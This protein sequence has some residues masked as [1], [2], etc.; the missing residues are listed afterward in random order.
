MAQNSSLDCNW[1]LETDKLYGVDKDYLWNGAP[2]ASA[3][4]IVGAYAKR[5]AAPLDCGAYDAIEYSTVIDGVIEFHMV[6]ASTID[7]TADF[8]SFGNADVISVNSASV[9]NTLTLTPGIW[10]RNEADYYVSHVITHK[11]TDPKS[12]EIPAHDHSSLSGTDDRPTYNGEYLALFKDINTG[13]YLPLSGG[14]MKGELRFNGG[15]AA[16]GSKI[17][18][19]EG[20]GQITDS[21][22]ITLFGF[23]GAKQLTAGHGNYTLRLRGTAAR[24]TY[25][26][27]DVALLSDIPSKLTGDYLPLSG[28][29]LTGAIDVSSTSQ[30]LDFGTTGYFR[31][32]TASGNRFDFFALINSTTLAVG[33]TY[34]ALALKGKNDRPTYNGSDMALKSDIPTVPTNVSSFANDAG[35]I[36]AVPAEYITETEL[37]AKGYATT[38]AM[39]TALNKKADDFSI[40]IYNGTAGNPKPV[41]F[42]SFNYSTCGSEEGIAAKISMVS[43]HGNGSSYAFLQDAIIR[44]THTGGVEVDNFKHYGA[45]VTDNGVERQY[46]DIFWLHDTTNKT[47]DFYCLMGQYARLYQTPWKR[48]TYSSKGS[49]TQYTAC[50]VYSSGTKTWANNSEYALISD[51]SGKYLPLSGGTVIGALTLE[52]IVKV[53]SQ[54]RVGENYEFGVEASEGMC[55][56]RS[57]AM[58]LSTDTKTLGLVL[59]R[60]NDNS[61]Q[62][63]SNNFKTNIVGSE[64]RP[65]YNGSDIALYSDITTAVGGAYL[66]LSGGALSGTLDVGDYIS[67]HKQGSIDAKSFSLRISNNEENNTT[68]SVGVIRIVSEGDLCLG[69]MFYPLQLQGQPTKRPT[70]NGNDLALYSDLA[71][72]AVTGHDHNG[73]YAPASHSHDYLPLTGGTMPGNIIINNA[74]A[75]LGMQDASGN[76]AYFQT[77]DDGS[78]NKAGFGY[79]WNRSLKLDVSGNVYTVGSIYEGGTALSSKY[80]TI[81]HAHD[82]LPL[83]GG[84][85][86]GDLS[87]NGKFVQGSP[88]SDASIASMNRLESDLF[89]QGNGAA[90]NTPGIAGFYLGKSATD[91]NRHLDIVSGDTYSYIDFNKAGRLT[92]YDVRLLVNVETGDTQFMW[93]Q[94]GALNQ[95][96]FNVVGGTLMQNG[97]PVALKSDLSGY[98]PTGHN[99]DGI[100]APA[101]HSHD[102]IYAPAEH[103]HESLQLSS[104]TV[105][106]LEATRGIAVGDYISMTSSGTIAAKGYWL[107]RYNS[108]VLNDTIVNRGENEEVTFGASSCALQLSGSEARPTYNASA[109]ALYS[110]LSG[111]APAGHN[112]D[113]LPLFGGTLSGDLDF[114]NTSAWIKPYLL[115]FKN[116]NPN[117]A[118]TYPYTGFYQWGDE[119]QVNARDANNTWAK[120]VMAINLVS[121][122]ANF[123]ARPTVNGSNIALSSDL[124]GYALTGHN[125]DSV[126]APLSHNHDGV[127][128]PAGHNHDYLPLSGGKITGKLEIGD[129][130]TIYAGGSVFLDSEL[131]AKEFSLRKYSNTDTFQTIIE[132]GANEELVLGNSGS[133]LQFLGKENQPTYNG[134]DLALYSDLSGYLP[135]SGGTV[136]GY[137]TVTQ[138]V[139]LNKNVYVGGTLSVNDGV[140]SIDGNGYV[141]G[142]WLKSTADIASS[143]AATEICVRSNGWIKSRTPA[144]ILSDIGAA[145]A[146]H[147]HDY[148]PLSGGNLSGHLYLVGANAT[149]STGNTSQIVFGTSSNNHVALSS[150]NN[151]LV[152]NPTAAS[153]ANQ[154]VLY[155][156]QSSL[157]P[158]GIT[159]N[160]TG[161]A[162]KAAADANGNNIASTYATKAELAAAGGGSL[163]LPSRLAS[164]QD[165]TVAISDANN[166]V[167]TGFYYVNAA[168]NRPSFSQSTNVDYR[169]LTTAYSD[170]WLQQIAT[171]FRCDDIFYRRRQQGAWTAWKQLAFTDTHLTGGLMTG[172]LKFQASS[173]PGKKL[174]YICGIDAFASGGEMGWQSK[175]DFL[176]GYATTSQLSSYLPLTGGTLTGSLVAPVYK[177]DSSTAA[178]KPSDSNE[179]NFGSNASYIYFG[180]ENRVGS[181][182]AVADYYFGTHS[183]AANAKKG[184]IWCGTLYEDGTALSDKYAKITDLAGYSP[185]SHNHEG[186]YAKIA[187]ANV[188]NGEQKF[189]NSAYCPTVT[190]TASGIGC[191]FK[192]SRGMTNEMLVDK[193][194]MTASTGKMPFY[195]YSGAANGQMTGLTEVAHVTST[196]CIITGSAEATAFSGIQSVR[197]CYADNDH[198]NTAGFIINADGASKFIHR[199]G[200]TSVMEDAYFSFDSAGFKM[201]ASG[202]KG[203]QPG[204]TPTFEALQNADRPTFKGAELALRSD[205]SDHTHSISNVSGLS[206]RLSNYDGALADLDSRLTSHKHD[207]AELWN[208][209]WSAGE[210]GV[211]GSSKYRLYLITTVGRSDGSTQ[212]TTILAIR[213]GNYIRGIGGYENGTP[214]DYTY[215][216]AATVNGDTWTFVGAGYMYHSA[217][218]SHSARTLLAVS[219]IEGVM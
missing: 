132:R 64:S 137:L 133:P 2:S 115:A 25:N 70:Y 177:S 75:Y 167:E 23:T 128:A 196:G 114:S 8:V 217:S 20:A 113:Y 3:L 139:Y 208:G 69:S 171:D 120:N 100:Y 43:G 46:G 123:V 195:T 27:A 111:Y 99:H 183:G 125:H 65:T 127:Y 16:G 121:G 215:H 73:V 79:G 30:V 141:T 87:V 164:Y 140:A 18:L 134:T 57:F 61:L 62:V 172:S 162:S 92:D 158:N 118:P 124:S 35:Y 50:T 12:D 32:M 119:W 90:P 96:Q 39:N 97:S 5:I 7:S 203:T 106:L 98:A 201:Y 40:E 214:T 191:A 77:Y 1:E 193:L 86:S 22:T 202:T 13:E 33:G 17:V 112:H 74:N 36:T 89:I 143:S 181:A 107:R 38:S 116:A 168:T 63:G 200:D 82:Y 44:V 154:I 175:A 187:T 68:S 51:I 186:V 11:I 26:S 163:T 88:S 126:Y 213:N 103:S 188:Y 198:A 14:T 178:I 147:G 10:V 165:H 142:T 72:Y 95:K 218:G 161:T 45:P 176:A 48:L 206:A 179:I 219:K 157:F 150:N 189:Q 197:K 31:G 190:D 81:G 71:G 52:G 67:I 130:A 15:D 53:K 93:G 131:V 146:S 148:L 216:F 47:I 34:P 58:P 28:G 66:P 117:A 185:T 56:S 151:A 129:G 149:S 209:N 80:S 156:D 194:V 4:E 78:G 104:C 94:D 109:L 205:T 152:I 184:R 155:L 159:G 207:C 212:G 170:Q 180:Y 160:L 182:G 173:L 19:V 144:Q 166:A 91:E 108:A 138:A 42:A 37:N 24:P 102:G 211:T 41:R 55:W 83:S 136:D 76:I 60:A 135:L 110:D 204:T 21:S 153:T 105:G 9:V 101:G 84:A 6:D 54:L 199:W 85:V 192:A 174:E 145:P 122:V 210:L 49:V 169:I 59:T 29:A